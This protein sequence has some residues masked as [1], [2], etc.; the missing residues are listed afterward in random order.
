MTKNY[1]YSDINLS[2]VRHPTSFDMAKR[3]DLSAIKSSVIHILSTNKGE[4]LFNPSFG[5]SL[6]ELLFE[7]ITP[8][9]KL[10]IK[11]RV[12]EEIE[13]WEPRVIV[14]NLN[15]ENG[16]FGTVTITVFFVLKENKTITENVTVNLTRVR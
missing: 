5:A 6:H 8:V 10:V 14:N 13:K 9:T 15:I 3:F 16:Q 12:I 11:K 7:L 2:L 4:K 1:I